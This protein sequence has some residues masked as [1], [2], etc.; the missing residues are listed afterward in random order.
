MMILSIV[1]LCTWVLLT[2]GTEEKV[3]DIPYNQEYVTE[4]QYSAI[5]AAEN[6]NDEALNSVGMAFLGDSSLF[7]KRNASFAAECFQLSGNVGNMQAAA[8]LAKLYYN[9]DGVPSSMDEALKWYQNAAMKGH[10]ASAYNSGLILLQSLS[11]SRNE[12]QSMK[13]LSAMEYFK[14]AYNESLAVKGFSAE[15]QQAARAAFELLSSKVSSVMVFNKTILTRLWRVSELESFHSGTALER[16]LS[17]LDRLFEYE[18]LFRES[19]GAP[20]IRLRDKHKNLVNSLIELHQSH[21]SSLSQLQNY[22]VLDN[23]QVTIQKL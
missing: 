11:V 22:L 9:G 1:L 21:S 5:K 18:D 4:K 19:N 6:G 8:N 16:W 23:I 2:F 17:F 13:I 14:Q 3:I 20:T 7:G 10:Q 12:E 15:T